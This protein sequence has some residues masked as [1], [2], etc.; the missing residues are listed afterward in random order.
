MSLTWWFLSKVVL[1]EWNETINRP[2]KK[3]AIYGVNETDLDWMESNH[4]CFK[5]GFC[6]NTI[7]ETVVF[8]SI[9]SDEFLKCSG[10]SYLMI[11]NN[12]CLKWRAV[13]G[14][15]FFFFFFPR[16]YILKFWNSRKDKMF[17][18]LTN[19]GFCRVLLCCCWSKLQSRNHIS[20]IHWTYNKQIKW[21]LQLVDRYLIVKNTVCF[22]LSTY[23]LY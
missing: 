14:L 1:A 23:I 4:C 11:R 6:R 3:N 5:G 21:F 15:L 18:W 9:Y 2:S 22:C 17:W 8:G 16:M 10:I 20:N 7:S 13:L 12:S 19:A